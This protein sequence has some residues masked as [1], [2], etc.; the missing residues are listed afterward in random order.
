MT[1]LHFFTVYGPW[2][3]P[4]MARFLFAQAIIESRPVEAFNHGHHTRD[5][6]YVE[7]T[8]KGI[9]RVT[10][11]VPR[12]GPTWNSA[13]LDPASSSAPYRLYNIG[14]N[15]L[16]KLMRYIE[17]L[18]DSMGRIAERIMKPLQICD[19]PGTFA[20]VDELIANINFFSPR[21]SASPEC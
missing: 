15:R 1:G 18:E 19:V 21:D 8:V 12:P 20:D 13:N 2:C 4:S 9:V 14:S 7:D 10:D 11:H 5:I 6:T 3:R 17:V 16:I